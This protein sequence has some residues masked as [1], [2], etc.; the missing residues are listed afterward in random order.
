MLPNISWGETMILLVAALV[1]LGPERLPGAIKWTFA[2][3]RKVR[4][5]ASGA[6]QHLREE[7]GPE[8]DAIRE[9]IAELQRMRGMSPRSVITKHLLDGDDSVLR[10]LEDAVR[11]E[12]YGAGTTAARY[13]L[14]T[15]SSTSGLTDHSLGKPDYTPLRAGERPP[16]DTDAT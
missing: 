14:L 2:A 1:I 9:P 15:G 13:D 7:I 5:Y 6:S 10:D 4:D 8:F 11:R 12:N 16:I 3:L